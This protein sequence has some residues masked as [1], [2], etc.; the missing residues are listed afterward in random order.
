MFLAKKWGI[1]IAGAGTHG[2]AYRTDAKVAGYYG[3][4]KNGKCVGMDTE[5]E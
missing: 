4:V 2:N 3:A 5:N 1:L